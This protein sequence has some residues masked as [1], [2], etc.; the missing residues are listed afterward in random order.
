MIAYYT[1]NEAPGPAVES[2][3]RQVEQPWLLNTEETG[4]GL[5]SIGGS[6]PVTTGKPNLRVM[7]VQPR[8]QA[9]TRCWPKRRKA[10][11]SI[12]M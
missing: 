2:L 8:I 9:L 10:F 3:S 1:S 6:A 11:R 4:S 7:S 12:H 5:R